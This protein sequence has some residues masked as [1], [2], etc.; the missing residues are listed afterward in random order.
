MPFARN[1]RVRREIS[2]GGHFPYTPFRRSATTAR[3]R[4]LPRSKYSTFHRRFSARPSELEPPMRRTHLG[5]FAIGRFSTAARVQSFARVVRSSGRSGQ[6]NM[7]IT[8]FLGSN[9]FL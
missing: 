6:W 7:A 2:T 4:Y 5:L 8:N 1:F 9:V 3:R